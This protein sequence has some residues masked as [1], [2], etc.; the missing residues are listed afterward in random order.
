MSSASSS[1]LFQPIQVGN[2]KLAHRVALAPLTRFRADENHV[3][4]DFVPEYYAQRGSVPGTLLVTEATYIAKKA[5]VFPAPGIHAPGIWSKEQIEQWKKVTAA[6]HAKGS[7]IFLQLWAL[8]RAADPEALAKLNL[9]YVSASD[10]P[11]PD[12]PAPRPLNVDEIHEYIEL[13][14]QAAKNAIEAGF[15]GVEVHGANGFLPDQFLQDVTNTR[16]DEYGGSIENRARF[17]LEVLT[18]VTKAIGEERT[19]IR[20]SP[21]ERAHAMGMADPRPTFT[22]IIQA[23]KERFPRF[24]YIHV[25]EPRVMGGADREVVPASESN[26]FVLE[27]WLPKPLVLAGGYTRELALEVAARGNVI[28]AFGR[29]FIA[30]PDLPRRL[31]EDIPLNK[32][33]RATFYTNGTEGYIDYPF[34]DQG[35]NG[36]ATS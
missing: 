2:V 26:D 8:G 10:V 34:A 33:N 35:E 21:W 16:T 1:N 31:K 6:V 22:Y 12:R 13:Y 28:V 27:S 24:A 3:P 4:F 14:A 17:P 7:Y 36:N 19:A 9:P 29:H 25:T 23:I 15:D 30:N 20:L 32:Y 5:G 18:A 11:L